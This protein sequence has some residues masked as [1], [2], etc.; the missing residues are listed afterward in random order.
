MRY[1]GRRI[2]QKAAGGKV[3]PLHDLHQLIMR[4]VGLIDQQ[5]GRVQDFM[6]IMRRDGGGHTDRDSCRAIG[7]QVREQPGHHLGLFIL[8]II[9]RAQIGAI[10]VQ[11]GHQLHRRLGQL[12]LGIPIGRGIIAIDIA[13]IALPVDQRIAQRKGL[14]EPH[15]RVI[16]RLIAM[17]MIFADD[18]AHHAGA[19]LVTLARVQPQQPHRPEQPPMHRLQPVAQIGQRPRGDGGHGID[20]IALGQRRIER[21]IDDL[22]ELVL[23]RLRGIQG[24]V[25]AHDCTG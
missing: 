13:E 7:Q 11:P 10:L 1:A 23:G 5:R 8:T 14:R 22:V 3:R 16:D 15:H 12:G 25:I 19:F 24:G 2:D 9:G 17:R 18:I 6:D 21:R 4:G 20:Q